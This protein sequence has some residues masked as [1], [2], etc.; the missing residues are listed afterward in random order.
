YTSGQLL[1]NGDIGV[2]VGDST[3]QQSFHFGKLDF[4]GSCVKK[5]TDST[6]NNQYVWQQ[7]AMTVGGLTISSP[8]PGSSPSSV[9]RMTQDILNAEV[10]TSMQFG[11]GSGH[12]VTVNMT[13][14]TADSNNVFVVELSSPP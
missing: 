4:W 6:D 2:A 14:W 5:P 7:G 11:D 12:N 10:R 8:N 9:F 13:G 3:T 1:G